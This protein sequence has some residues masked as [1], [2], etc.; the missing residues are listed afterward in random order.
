MELPVEGE[1]V[2]TSWE[3]AGFCGAGVL[4]VRWVALPHLRACMQKIS[5]WL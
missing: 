2:V 3:V 1:V 5:R 4:E